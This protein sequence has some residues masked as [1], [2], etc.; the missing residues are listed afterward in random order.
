LTHRIQVRVKS[1]PTPAYIARL[2]AVF[3]NNVVGARG[4]PK[5]GSARSC[6]TPKC[7]T[8]WGPP[9]RGGSRALSSR[10]WRWCAPWAARLRRR[11]NGSGHSPAGAGRRARRIR[12]SGF[13][14]RFTPCRAPRRS[15]R[16]F[17]SMVRL[18]GAAREFPWASARESGG[19]HTGLLR[20]PSQF[21]PG[22]RPAGRRDWPRLHRPAQRPCAD[23]AVQP[24]WLQGARRRLPARRHR[25]PHA[26][27][28]DERRRAPEISGGPRLAVAAR[29][30]Y[31][32]APDRSEKRHA[33]R[34]Q[35]RPGGAV[36]VLGPGQT[37]GRRDAG[38]GGKPTTRAP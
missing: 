24:I 28:A 5:A 12:S 9:T 21:S 36:S 3:G 10:R 25:R 6:S 16:S 37:R 17:K 19:R 34:S 32:G 14:R 30:H 38:D 33:L 31:P 26:V 7:A 11:T 1:N 35:R 13:I 18:A 23:R 15:S 4:D 8:R 27:V 20:L 29:R 22:N 2:A